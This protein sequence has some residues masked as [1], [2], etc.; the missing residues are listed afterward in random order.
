LPTR[1]LV[2]GAAIVALV[3]A[4][5]FLPTFSMQILGGVLVLA[6]F[7]VAVIWVVAAVVRR[8]GKTPT[9]AAPVLSAELV[10]PEQHEGGPTHA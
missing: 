3:L 7:L 1:T 4:G 9:L 5:V 10:G 6:V 2:V 8:S